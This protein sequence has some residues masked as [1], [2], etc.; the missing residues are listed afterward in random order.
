MECDEQ[1]KWQKKMCNFTPPK[2]EAFTFFPVLL[3]AQKVMVQST[4]PPTDTRLLLL[5]G[6]AQHG[7]HKKPDG[8]F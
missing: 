3:K 5:F 8:P 2:E 6:M 1:K 4:A 7:R